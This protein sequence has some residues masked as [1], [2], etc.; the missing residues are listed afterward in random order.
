MSEI[1]IELNYDV[2]NKFL[3]GYYNPIIESLKKVLFDKEL[4]PIL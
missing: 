2:A 3:N 1:I 4:L